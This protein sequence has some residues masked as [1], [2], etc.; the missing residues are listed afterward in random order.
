LSVIDPERH[1]S[2]HVTITVVIYN[3]ITGGV[4][5]EADVIAAIDDLEALYAACSDE[6]RLADETFDFMKEEL[7]VEDVRDI[8]LKLINQ[9]YK[10]PPAFVIDCDVFPKDAAR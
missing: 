7:A 10:P 3:T 8:G 4:P 1:S 6:G 9:P 2:E 5:S